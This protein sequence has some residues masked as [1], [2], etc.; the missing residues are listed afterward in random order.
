MWTLELLRCVH[1]L[2]GLGI[3]RVL[4]FLIRGSLFGNWFL[5][6]VGG[7]VEILVQTWG[8]R[9]EVSSA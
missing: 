3:L 8:W 9:I 5:S 2:I 1:V 6:E 4:T 7:E